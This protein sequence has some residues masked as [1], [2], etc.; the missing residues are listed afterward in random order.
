MSSEFF[1]ISN[2]KNSRIP[3]VICQPQLLPAIKSLKKETVTS[4]GKEIETFN[5]SLLNHLLNH[6]S[7]KLPSY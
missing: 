2:S 4:N 5:D 1:K 6:Q 7:T 3:F